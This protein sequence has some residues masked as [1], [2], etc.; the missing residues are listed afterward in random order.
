MKPNPRQSHPGVTLAEILVVIAIVAILALV[1]FLTTSRM[2]DSARSAAT[3]GQLRDIGVAVTSWMGDNGGYFPPCWNGDKNQSYAQVLDPYMHGMENFRRAE[4]RFIGIDK[5]IEVKIRTGSHP[6]TFSMNDAICPNVTLNKTD[7]SKTLKLVH[8]SRVSRLSD[9][10]LMADGCQNPNN[11]GQAN[12]SAFRVKNAVGPSGPDA[13][14][15]E[16]IPVGPDV[17]EASAAGWFRYP[18]GKCHAL[19]CDGAARA[20]SK[21]SITKGNVWMDP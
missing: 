19:M 18:Y 6:I 14:R 17:D 15:D 1:L 3:L 7:P 10:I 2:R 16:P 8:S 21:G 11:L 5:R 9:M 13:R 20:F 4:S 12:A